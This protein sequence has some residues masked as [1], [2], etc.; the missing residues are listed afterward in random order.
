MLGAVTLTRYRIIID[1]Q[2][3]EAF[4]AGLD[5]QMTA[6]RRDGQT[7]LVGEFHDQAQLYGLL[8]RLRGLGMALVS[9]HAVR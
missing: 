1:G 6:E 9:V 8:N 7:A 2:L 3:S 4:V 5:A